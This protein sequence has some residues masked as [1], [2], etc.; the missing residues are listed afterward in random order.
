[1]LESTNLVHGDKLMDNGEGEAIYYAERR[2]EREKQL[3]ADMLLAAHEEYC[4]ARK[5]HPRMNSLHEGYA[6]LLEEV[7][8]LWEEVKKRSALRSRA[9]M[10]TELIQIA[11]M[12]AALYA[13]VVTYDADSPTTG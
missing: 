5:K 11:A 6:V 13:E 10:K 2:K 4:N 7:D 3:A 8:E 9:N 12:A 1:M